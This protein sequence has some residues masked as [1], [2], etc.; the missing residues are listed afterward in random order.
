MIRRNLCEG[1][2][3]L[4]VLRAILLFECLVVA[5]FDRGFLKLASCFD[6]SLRIGDESRTQVTRLLRRLQQNL[7]S[8]EQIQQP[9]GDD[10]PRCIVVEAPV[11]HLIEAEFALEHQKRMFDFRPYP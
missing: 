9:T 11:A 5:R 7:L 6:F 8:H 1:K 2:S 4:F 10:Q 3:D